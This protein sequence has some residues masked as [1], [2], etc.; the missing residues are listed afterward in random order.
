MN[1]LSEMMFIAVIHN[2]I[3]WQCVFYARF[4]KSLSPTTGNIKNVLKSYVQGG[5]LR[6]VYIRF[7][8]QFCS[9]SQ[10]KH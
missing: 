8:S 4:M 6:T 5:Q 1:T 2:R 3:A 9:V 10:F 7:T